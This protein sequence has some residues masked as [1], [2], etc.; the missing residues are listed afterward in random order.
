MC[1]RDRRDDEPRCDIGDDIAVI[2][3]AE[4]SLAGEADKENQQDQE[5]DDRVI[6]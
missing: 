4:E 1:I 5:Y 6:A 3:A 2:R